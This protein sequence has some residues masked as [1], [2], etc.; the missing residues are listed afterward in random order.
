MSDA[1]KF[2]ELIT[3]IVGHNFLK[4]PYEIIYDE[5]NNHFTTR[6]PVWFDQT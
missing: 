4:V 6:A 1:S 5:I 3:N 2:I